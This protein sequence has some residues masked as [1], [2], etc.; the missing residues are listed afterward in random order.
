MCVLNF[1]LK[2]PDTLLF[3]SCYWA[4]LDM[5]KVQGFR[6]QKQERSSRYGQ[7]G[8]HFFLCSQIF[9]VHGHG[10]GVQDMS[11]G[12]DGHIDRRDGL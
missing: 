9:D 2:R 10:F 12:H 7:R 3:L 1:L 4:C 11:T 5:S 6:Q 8:G